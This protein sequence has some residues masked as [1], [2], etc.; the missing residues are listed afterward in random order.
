MLKKSVTRVLG[1]Q[2][3]PL[4]LEVARV[5]AAARRQAIVFKFLEISLLGTG[6]PA[7]RGGFLFLVEKRLE[8]TFFWLGKSRDFEQCVEVTVA[9]SY[10]PR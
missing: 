1:I 4:N 7:E 9:F 3:N 6:R 10:C 2:G 8:V 5:T